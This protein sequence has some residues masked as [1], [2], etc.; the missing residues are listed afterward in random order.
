MHILWKLIH[1]ISN[2][3]LPPTLNTSKTFQQQNNNYTQTCCELF[4]QTFHKHCQTHKTNRFINRV[5]HKTQVY[6]ITLTTTQVQDKD[7]DK[8][9]SYRP[10]SFLS[11]IVKALNSKHTKHTHATRVQNTTQYSYGTTHIKQHRS[12]GVQP[13]GSPCVDHHCSTRY[14]KIF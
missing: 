4:H 10:I 7:I 5:T 3:A 8:G 12:N 2:R 9:T 14:E 11:V 13:N 6:N 1:G